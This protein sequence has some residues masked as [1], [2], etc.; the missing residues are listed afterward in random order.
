MKPCILLLATIFP[1]FAMNAQTAFDNHFQ[2]K[3]M[4][5]DYYHS[6]NASEERF[7]VDEI[8]CDGPWSGSCT[9]LGDPLDLGPYRFVV[10]DGSGKTE[11]YSE[12]FASIFGEW[13]TIPEARSRWGCYHE[14]VRIP[15]PKAPVTLRI[16]KRDASNNFQ[17]VWQQAIDPDYRQINPNPPPAAYQS[18]SLFGDDDPEHRLDIVILGD[19]YTAL[20]MDKFRQDAQRLGNVLLETEPYRS[21][22]NKIS[23]RAVQTPAQES[24]VTRPHAALFRNSPLAVRYSAFDSERYALSSDNKAVRNAAATVPYDFTII[25]INERTYGGGGIYKLYATVAADNAF[26]DYIVIHEMGHHLAA[27]ADEYYTSAVAYET[28]TPITIEPWEKNVTAYLNGWFKWEDLVKKGTPLPTPW[29]KEAF[30]TYGRQV[31]ERRADIRTRQAPESEM[32]ALFREQLQTEQGQFA[33]MKYRNK[34]GLFEGANY[35]AQGYYRSSADCTM[36][37]RSMNF[38]PVCQMTIAQVIDQMS[39]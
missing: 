26:A 34:V 24:G 16:D 9:V 3:T 36:F 18:V 12:G 14:S 2:H 10:L 13:Q 21:M 27:L 39:R 11:L 7:A 4:R 37:T 38:C 1:L 8:R 35:H 22:K 20:E 23:I 17:P 32:E 15:W 28:D 6:G 31:E 25:L 19:G 33:K 30:E 29:D 5:I